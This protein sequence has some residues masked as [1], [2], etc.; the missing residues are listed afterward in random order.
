LFYVEVQAEPAVAETEPE[1]DVVAIESADAPG[2]P[3]AIGVAGAPVPSE[4]P[5]AFTPSNG[6][7]AV[8]SQ[9][10]A[11]PEPESAPQGEH[12]KVADVL[13]K[14]F[15]QPSRPANLQYSAPTVDGEGGV[16]RHAEANPAQGHSVDFGEVS[17]NAPCPCGSGRKYKRCHGAPANRT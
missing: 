3:P 13:G 9:Q 14:A 17:R 8:G 11:T 16:E 6:V 15:G 4:A 12:A 2:L 5:A 10:A 7:E 1:P